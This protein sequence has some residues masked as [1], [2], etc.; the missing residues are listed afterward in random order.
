MK[1]PALMT[2]NNTIERKSSI[3]FWG[4]ML[5]KHISWIDH[6]RTVESKIAK[7]IGLLYHVSQFLN[8]DS[9]KTLYFSV[10]YPYIL[11]TCSVG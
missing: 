8:E 3:R 6:V 11:S 7:D 9:L 4:V 10:V 2:G 5:D 1:L